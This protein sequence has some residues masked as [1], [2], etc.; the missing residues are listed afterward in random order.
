[1]FGAFSQGTSSQVVLG[2]VVLKQPSFGVGVLDIALCQS[3][4]ARAI[5]AEVGLVGG[6]GCALV[7]AGPAVG[8][9]EQPDRSNT[10]SKLQIEWRRARGIIYE[11][12]LLI[13]TN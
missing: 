8:P 1:V 3:F 13:G 4:G 9:L 7:D 12:L 11:L 10:G 2:Y 6:D 5:L